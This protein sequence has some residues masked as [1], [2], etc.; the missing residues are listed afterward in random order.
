M[1][2]EETVA[3]LL[4]KNE[5]LGQ[6][7][8]QLKA[9]LSVVK[10]NR[11]LRA[12]MQSFNNDTLEELTVCSPIG[13]K[14]SSLCQ[15]TCDERQFRKD[16]QQTKFKHE[17]RTSSPVDFKSFIQNSMHIDTSGFQSNQVDIPLEVKGPDRLLGEIAYQLDRRILSHI[18]QGHRRLYGFTLLNIPEKIIE[19]RIGWLLL[20]YTDRKSH[21]MS[22]V[23]TLACHLE[24]K[25]DHNIPPD[26]QRSHKP[27]FLFQ[28]SAHPLTGKVDEGY[29][30]HL[31]HRYADLMES[32][33]QL[34]YK[35]ALHPPFTEFIVNAYGILKERPGE[36]STQL[37]DYNN[38]NFLRKLIMTTAP[39]KLQ[40]D[41]LLVLTCLW[42]MAEKDKKPL[43]L[44]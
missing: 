26:S 17:H 6:E 15:N 19:N 2:L 31:T 42:N 11:D 28:V 39:R 22:K 25:T 40:K 36:N 1:D 29:R 7:N 30:L 27:Y 13:R 16:L 12:R 8:D 18:F 3:D 41:L 9:M 33:H 38:S 24:T 37:M 43:L 4:S 5:Q 44:W 34:G 32:L 23:L 14:P 10:E 35:A 20:Q 21:H